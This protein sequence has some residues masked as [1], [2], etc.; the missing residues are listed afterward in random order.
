LNSGGK[1]KRR[2]S[3]GVQD[4]LWE[5]EQLHEINLRVDNIFNVFGAKIGQKIEAGTLL[6]EK[7]LN[8]IREEQAKAIRDLAT[9]FLDKIGKKTKDLTDIKAS[10]R[11]EKDKVDELQSAVQDL[12]DKNNNLKKDAVTLKNDKNQAMRDKDK[13]MTELQNVK[14][15][16][17]AQMKSLEGNRIVCPPADR[18]EVEEKLQ[19]QFAAKLAKALQDREEQYNQLKEQTDDMVQ[20]LM[21]DTQQRHEKQVQDLNNIIDEQKKDLGAAQNDLLKRAQ[22]KDRLKRELE[23]EKG[24]RETAENELKKQKEQ[25]KDEGKRAKEKCDQLQ[26]DYRQICDEHFTLEKMNL[27]LRTEIEAL[28]K[29]LDDFEQQHKIESPVRPKKRRRTDSSLMEPKLLKSVQGP[30]I[31]SHNTFP[32]DCITQQ[33]EGNWKGFEL[34][35][36]WNQPITVKGWYLSDTNQTSRLP[37]PEKKD[38]SKGYYSCMLGR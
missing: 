23:N 35:N 13:A 4:R 7:T 38:K 29:K 16:M 24:L 1:Q 30:I 36:Q 3:K 32:L 37:L 6:D 27:D 15:T 10:L 31:E 5:K 17:D 26:N 14:D 11:A 18:A 28:K 25:N 33:F 12:T 2:G 8:E 20:K 9:D 22:D 19:Q 34:Q 21:E